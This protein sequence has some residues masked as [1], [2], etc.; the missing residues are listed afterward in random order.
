MY[1]WAAAAFA[2]IL[3]LVLLKKFKVASAGQWV[4]S[5]SRDIVSTIGNTTLSDLD[6]E[7]AMRGFATTL[8]QLFLV[9]LLGGAAA[10]A[11]PIGAL[12][13]L[14]QTGLVSIDAI[15]DISLSPVFIGATLFLG[16]IAYLF[17]KRGEPSST[18][19]T[20]H[21]SLMDRMVHHVAFRTRGAQIALADMEDKLYAGALNAVE[22]QR[23]VFVMALPRA[24]T[25]LL[26]QILESD[27]RFCS[28]TY[29]DMPLLLVPIL[30]SKLS[31]AFHKTQQLR[32]RAHG[33]G[34]LVGLDSPE[35]F[36][37]VIWSSFWKDQYGRQS[38]SPW[39]PALRYEE[40][41]YFFKQH[42]KKI[43]LL[44]QTN[45]FGPGRYLSKNNMN[46]ARIGY[47]T[48]IFP[49]GAVIIPF[50]EPLQHAASLLKQ[51]VAFLQMHKTDRFAAKYMRDI[52][53][54]DFGENLKPINFDNWFNDWSDNWSDAQ[55][56]QESTTELTFWLHYWFAAYTHILESLKDNVFLFP[57]DYFCVQPEE[58]LIALAEEIG[59]TDQ[60]R[61]VAQAQTV[62]NPRRH[63][64]NTDNIPK[65]LLVEANCLYDRL[66]SAAI[67]GLRL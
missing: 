36:E 39:N 43:I 32:E 38:V 64:V 22:A 16:G 17:V 60:A 23:P 57:Y 40:F 49:Q 46:I 13:L 11:V 5:L 12:W 65:D 6:K 44:R 53:H 66:N 37:E 14:E 10:L 7:K 18:K 26:L 35:A 33:D 25:T 9:I 50:R 4:L 47:L 1:D 28:H 42:I 45:N 67:Y 34:M 29:R 41:E 48:K 63:V 61:F 20:D 2:A 27:G 56:A 52:G 54:Y 51:H 3:F 15:I 19:M 55:K 31:R 24:G 8:F 59:I 30:W 62:S 58:C 21:Y